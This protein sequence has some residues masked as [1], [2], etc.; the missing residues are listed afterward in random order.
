MQGHSLRHPSSCLSIFPVVGISPN[1]Y[2][3]CASNSAARSWKTKK[4]LRLTPV[5]EPRLMGGATPFG[6]GIRLNGFHASAS[7]PCICWDSKRI[8]TIRVNPLKNIPSLSCELPSSCPP[9]QTNC[10]SCASRLRRIPL[11]QPS[12]TAT[13]LSRLTSHPSC[14]RRCQQR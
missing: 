6:V 10:P 5:E 13:R 11:G 8:S 14:S 7:T 2:R 9:L 1:R 3:Q 4:P 12:S